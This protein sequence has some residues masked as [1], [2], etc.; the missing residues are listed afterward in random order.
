M[1]IIEVGIMRY[2]LNDEHINEIINELKRI[3]GIN[4]V[5]ENEDLDTQ[6]AEVSVVIKVEAIKVELERI[7]ILLG[8]QNEVELAVQ[9]LEDLVDIFNKIE[10]GLFD[11]DV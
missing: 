2:I 8:E 9:K 10:I 11:I 3:D 7:L 1:L 4:V 6:F 5:V